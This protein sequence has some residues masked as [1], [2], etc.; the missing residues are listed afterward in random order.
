[1]PN[2][3][4]SGIPQGS[5]LSKYN[6]LVFFGAVKYEVSFLFLSMLSMY[7]LLL[8]VRVDKYLSIAGAIG[9]AFM[10]FTIS[11]FEAGHITKVLAMSVMPGA[12]AGVLLLSQKRY[13]LG[14]AV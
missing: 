4:I 14:A 7:V 2:S 12:L 1:M 3:L 5:V 10:T 13:L 6:P 8:S 9:Y 11:S